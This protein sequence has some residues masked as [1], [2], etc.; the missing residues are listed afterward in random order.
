MA[1]MITKKTFADHDR[2]DHRADL[3]VRGARRE[4]LRSAPRRDA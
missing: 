1:G 3:K 4:Q 2:P